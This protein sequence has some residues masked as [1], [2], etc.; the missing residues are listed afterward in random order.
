MEDGSVGSSLLKKVEYQRE[1]QIVNQLEYQTQ[2][3]LSVGI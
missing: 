2:P 3:Y 1:D